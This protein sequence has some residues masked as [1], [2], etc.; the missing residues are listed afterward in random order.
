MEGLTLASNSNAALGLSRLLLKLG[1][2]LN[3]ATGA[4]LVVSF[5]VTFVFEDQVRHYFEKRAFD[6]AILMP[7]L[8]IW[9]ILG[10]PYVAAIHVMLARLLAMVETVRLG[11]PFVPENA[12]RLKTI[13]WCLLATQL[14]HLVFG[15]MVRI[16][17]S[18]N[19]HMEWKFSSS[20]WIAVLL[21]FVL[22]R[23]FEEGTR[24]R[25]DLEKM[26]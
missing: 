22:A 25:D 13:A 8:R 11:N 5:A 1:A 2:F 16:A 6:A 17:A 14:L 3:L 9:M 21:L 19:A 23:V 26:I 4:I 20:G 12:V 15:L 18:A 24:L 7:T 10:L